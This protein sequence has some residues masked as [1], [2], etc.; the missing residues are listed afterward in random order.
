MKTLI[1][2]IDV[3]TAGS[4]VGLALAESDSHDKATLLNVQLC[5][6]GITPAQ[7]VAD[8]I[9]NVQGPILLAIDAPL[10][11]PDKMGKELYK[12]SA[13]KVLSIL[14][15]EFFRR[16]TDRFVQRQI[17]KTPL[18]V[19]ADRIARTAHAALKFLDDL[20]K[21]LGKTIP[22]AWSPDFSGIS[23]IEV[24][25]AATLKAWGIR[26]SGYK[27]KNQEG[28]RKEI[29]KGLSSWVEVGR[30]A[31]ELVRNPD[32]LDGVACV[33]SGMDFISGKA[34]K[35]ENRALAEREGWIWVREP[36][37]QKR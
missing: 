13:G 1:I 21:L 5:G 33:V 32:V 28:E 25:P 27:A 15:N 8:W 23:A 9:K 17:G 10:G 37:Y 19:G 22:L 29:L 7:T 36:L 26:S 11:W 30:Y 20:R 14:P 4:K 6:K 12:H 35:P 2:G 18:D 16:E 34:M 3:A 31:P 24:Y